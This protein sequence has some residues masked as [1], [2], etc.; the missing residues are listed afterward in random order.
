MSLRL[1]RARTSLLGLAVLPLIAACQTPAPTSGDGLEAGSRALPDSAEAAPADPYQYGIF[2][3]LS[4]QLARRNGQLPEAAA[5]FARTAVVSGRA[6]LYGEAINAALQAQAGKAA[7]AYA[8][9]WTQA[10]PKRPEPLLALARARA[11]REDVEGAAKAMGEL[12]TAHPDAERELLTAGERLAEVGGVSV[13]VQVLRATAKAH[14]DTAAGHLAYGHLLARL[15]Q[16]DAASGELARARE[17]RP[18][19]EVAVVELAKS[20]S[21]EE[22]LAILKDYLA[23]HPQALRARL[24]YAQGL[25]AT[26]QP[27]AAEEVYAGLGQDR[28]E[29]AEVVMGLGLA[30]YHQQDW[31]GAAAAF[32]RVLALDAGNSAALFHLGRIAE[33]RGDYEAASGYYARVYSG[34]YREQARLREAVTAVRTDDLERALQLIRQMRTRHPNEPEYYRLEARILA[35]MDQLKAAEQVAG[36]GLQGSP[37]HVELLYTRA[38]VR[39]QRGNYAGMEADIRRV[40]EQRP[41][42][43]RAYNFLGYSLADRGV[44]LR[45]ALDLVQKAQ[46]L[47]PEAGYVIDS[48]GWVHYRL[49][50]LDKA[51][52]LLRRALQLTPQDAEILSHLGEVLEAQGRANEARQ[53]WQKALDRA[54]A[55]S[56][57]ARELRRRLQGAEE[58]NGS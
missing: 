50:D 32:K 2:A 49:G 33:E 19:W 18:D 12:V 13:A 51:E 23:G 57:L 15:G 16:R 31:A 20:L 1:P 34:R 47:E 53:T 36:R 5:W 41:E 45:E 26:D 22:G 30:R 14:P 42:Q 35:E 48:L 46:E 56:R 10:A 9:R 6:D 17:L 39:E 27:Q 58:V 40:I 11:Q 28:P 54:E 29:S 52:Q 4:A 25:L 55:G 7:E 37:N 43:A 38:I 21:P 44:R 24:R 3:Y 8:A